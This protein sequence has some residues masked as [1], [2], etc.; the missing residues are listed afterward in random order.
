MERGAEG[1]SQADRYRELQNFRITHYLG[2][3]VQEEKHKDMT[4]E[5]KA[6]RLIYDEWNMSIES[7]ETHNGFR[8]N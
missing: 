8:R 7:Y 1:T 2:W 3:L 6:L 5:M 4:D